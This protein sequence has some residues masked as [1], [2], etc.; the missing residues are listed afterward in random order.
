MATFVLVPGF[1]LGAWA[2]RD[3]VPPLRALGHDVYPMTLTGLG[4][5][6]HLAGPGVN[7]T[8]HIT[9]V[10]SLIDAEELRDVVLVGHSGASFVIAGVSDRIPERLSRLVYVDTPAMPDGFA[11][12]DTMPPAIKEIVTRA[13]AGE[14]HGLGWPLPEWAAMRDVLGEN[15]SGITDAQL[16]WVRRHAAA[17]PAGMIRE[18]LRLTNDARKAVPRVGILSTFTEADVRAFVADGA[19]WV[20]EMADPGWRFIELPTG[21][22]PMFSRPA[23]LARALHEAATT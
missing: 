10:V 19:D 22:W 2:W 4:D 12:I 5:R 3:V 20:R 11:H 13:I 15:L 9:D 1:W 6:A 16:A 17:Q 8:T 14:G 21:H 23:D 18:P 7:L